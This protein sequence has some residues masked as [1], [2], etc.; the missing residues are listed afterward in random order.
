M[1]VPFLSVIVTVY[2]REKYL[3]EA[4]ESVFAQSRPADEIIVVDDGSTDRSAEVARSFGPQVQ[5]VSQANQGIGGARNTAIALTRGDLIAILDS[6][7]IWASN[8]LERQC[9]AFAEH[10]EL[11]AVFCRMKPFLSPELVRGVGR[12]FNESESD[13]LNAPALMA[14]RKVF[15]ETG[16]FDTSLRIGEFICWFG[17][18]REN[19]VRFDVLPEVLLH[20][21]IH[22][23]NS[24]HQH[25]DQADYLR[26]LKRQLVRR[27]AAPGR[28][29]L[30]ERE[31]VMV[32]P[33]AAANSARPL[34]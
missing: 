31:G 11:D 28:S 33:A 5:V 18:A 3:V 16:P 19:G 34:S 9:A 23:T 26:V 27:R 10:P 13:A 12:A 20:R 22:A 2:N 32:N 29:V 6:D 8:K 14:R 24:V 17:R 21:R 4:L 30:T 7:D 1:A 25:A 15:L